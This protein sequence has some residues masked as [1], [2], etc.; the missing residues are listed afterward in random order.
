[1]QIKER[2]QHPIIQRIAP[3]GRD[4]TVYFGL[5]DLIFKNNRKNPI[6]LRVYLDKEKETHI[7]EIMGR[8]I[9]HIDVEIKTTIKETKKYVVVRTYREIY[10]ERK[11]IKKEKLSK[12]KYKKN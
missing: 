6:K 10:K 1:M 11:L 4:A 12:D 3:A 5:I 7:F 2:K 9:E 8:N